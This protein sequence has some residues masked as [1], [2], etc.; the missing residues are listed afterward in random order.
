MLISTCNIP[1]GN[2]Y[3]EGVFLSAGQLYAC[4]CWLVVAVLAG[5]VGIRPEFTHVVV[6][7]LSWTFQQMLHTYLQHSRDNYTWILRFF[8]R[9]NVD[10]NSSKKRNEHRE[11]AEIHKQMGFYCCRKEKSDSNDVTIS[12]NLK[13]SGKKKS[14]G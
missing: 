6:K 4:K 8:F 7:F 9:R 10:T 1:G 14:E 11:S 5:T 2:S 3:P 12:T 13:I